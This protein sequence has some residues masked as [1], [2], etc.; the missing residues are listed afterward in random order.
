[1][2]SISEKKK[3]TLQVL[4]EI[5]FSYK[6]NKEINFEIITKLLYPNQIKD[7]L[8]DQQQQ[9][10]KENEIKIKTEPLKQF[11]NEKYDDLIDTDEIINKMRDPKN[12][13]I[14]KNRRYYLKIYENCFLGNEMV[15]WILKNISR[16]KTRE[17]AVLFGQEILEEGYFDHVVKE[18][19]FKDQELFYRFKFDEKPILQQSNSFFGGSTTP[20]NSSTSNNN[21]N[22]NGTTISLMDA[23][24]IEYQKHQQNYLTLQSFLVK[25]ISNFM[26]I[27]EV[28]LQASQN[29]SQGQITIQLIQN[30][31]IKLSKK[32]SEMKEI[33]ILPNVEH[34]FYI[35]FS[36]Y[37]TWKFQSTNRLN[38]IQFFNEILQQISNI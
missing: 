34:G 26:M 15:D 18:K 3:K 25:R 35:L 33:D 6:N 11:L 32:A 21:S 17:D 27:S 19:P 38:C 1:M 4:K 2:K 5:Y 30:Q 29:I 13:I 8:Y 31:T 7:N 12:G 22:G 28:E 23:K 37:E 20:R 10:N 14:I 9:E 36:N 24:K 16:V